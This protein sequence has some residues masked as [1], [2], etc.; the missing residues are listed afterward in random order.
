M[1]T[2]YTPIP[3]VNSQVLTGGSSVLAISAGPNGGLI[4]NPYTAS[5]QG[6]SVAEVL[7]VNPIGFSSTTANG[8]TFALLPGQTWT[9][10]PGQTTPT[11]VNAPTSGHKFS[12]VSW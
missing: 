4:T 5:D 3:G 11:Y 1:T 10:I 6:L 2:S 9:I 12:V 8:T 7:Y